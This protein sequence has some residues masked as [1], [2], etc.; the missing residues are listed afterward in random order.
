MPRLCSWPTAADQLSLNAA[1]ITSAGAYAAGTFGLAGQISTAANLP[2]SH[3]GAVS[4]SLRI[5]A[6]AD[7]NGSNSVSAADLAVIKTN[8]GA[9]PSTFA[10]GDVGIQFGPTANILPSGG[11]GLGV[12][13]TART[14]CGPIEHIQFGQQDQPFDNAR[15]TISSPGGTPSGSACQCSTSA[16]RT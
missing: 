5:A 11:P 12:T 13:L 6:I 9:S 1:A 2:G 16:G 4:G 7:F 8:F 10:I 3:A 15:V 14:G